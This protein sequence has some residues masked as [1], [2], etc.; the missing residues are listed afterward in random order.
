M[1]AH[2]II[3]VTFVILLVTFS[4]FALATTIYCIFINIQSHLKRSSIQQSILDRTVCTEKSTY[5]MNELTKI[6]TEQDNENLVSTPVTS[7]VTR[8]D[9]L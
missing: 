7:F 6:T 8:Q 9:E 1:E 5:H 3:A 4:L 2:E